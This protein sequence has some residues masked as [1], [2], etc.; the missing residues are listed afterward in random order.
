MIID[1]GILAVLAVTAFYLVVMP[2]SSWLNA[3]V[4]IPRRLRRLAKEPDFPVNVIVPCKGRNKGLEENLR[5]VLSQDYPRYTVTMVT[6]T[7][8]DE[9]VETIRAVV[10]DHPNARHLVVGYAERTCGK[11]FAQMRAIALD[12]TSDVFVICDSD[13]RPAPDYVRRM[14]KPYVDPRVCATSSGRW[15]SSP[16]AGLASYMYAAFEG[17][18]TMMLASPFFP[19][20]WGGSFSISR[21][22]YDGL[23][24]AQAWSN[25]E[26][27]DLV[28]AEILRKR[29]TRAVFVADAVSTG[30]ELHPTVDHFSRWVTRQAFTT[31]LHMFHV[32]LL[33]LLI[34]TVVSLGIVAAAGLIAAQAATTSLDFR[35]LVAAAFLLMVLVNPLWMKLPYRGRKDIPLA[36]WILLSVPAHFVLAFSVWRSAVQQ[37]MYWGSVVV[38]FNRDSTI[39][40]FIGRG[41]GLSSR[42]ESGTD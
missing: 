24:I 38:E 22:A 12:R 4:L 36:A 28:L 41:D 19:T 23:E 37:R 20:I 27:D 42:R 34:E 14:V 13:L 25:K 17:A 40:R 18:P 6:D 32:W 10:R 11:N 5:A 7:D 31:R 15:I 33:L 2:L 35:A 21:K 39:R 16:P 26:D 29:H 1:W 9:A 3:R 30:H 8:H